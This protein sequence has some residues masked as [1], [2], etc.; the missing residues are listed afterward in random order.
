MTYLKNRGML[1]KEDIPEDL[2][3]NDE[4]AAMNWLKQNF[5]ASSRHEKRVEMLSER[6]VKLI[7]EDEVLST[8][9]T[10]EVSGTLKAAGEMMNIIT[11]QMPVG[12]ADAY[13]RSLSN[14]GITY[15][16]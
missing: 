11:G 6:L 5:N 2:K 16:D 3:F 12:Q 4:T 8:M 1:T 14:I 13:F 15:P 10:N 9:K 7:T